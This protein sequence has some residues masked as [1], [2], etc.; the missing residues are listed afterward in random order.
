MRNMRRDVYLEHEQRFPDKSYFQINGHIP[1]S[2]FSFLNI[3]IKLLQKSTKYRNPLKIIGINL[4]Y[5]KK[6]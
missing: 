6:S 2:K 1:V 3:L 5:I 4:I